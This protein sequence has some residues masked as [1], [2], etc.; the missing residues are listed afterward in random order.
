MDNQNFYNTINTI[1]PPQLGWLQAKLPEEALKKMWFYIEKYKNVKNF[2]NV[3]AG[4]ISSSWMLNDDDNWFYDN[5]LLNLCCK[6]SDSFINLG[7]TYGVTKKHLYC[8]S[9]FWVN[10]QK[11]Y[12]FN[13]FHV[14]Q[15]CIYSFVIWMNI[16][17]DYREQHQI[18]ISANSSIPSTS[19]FQFVY[20]NMLRETKRYDY[21]LDKSYEGTILFFPANLAH[22]VY[23][24]FN[25]DEYRISISGNIALNTSSFIEE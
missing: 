6:Y 24:F 19:N 10:F 5:I 23:P 8:L 21:Y 20:L 2:N 16:P 22:Q 4:N 1:V 13:P 11:K 7:Q 3:L 25:C 18:P 14:H 12:E 9:S 15:N 17:Y